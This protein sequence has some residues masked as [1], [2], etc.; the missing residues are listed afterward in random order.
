METLQEQHLQ[1]KFISLIE[2]YD[3]TVA[4]ELLMDLAIEIKDPQK[5]LERIAEL[6]D[7]LEIRYAQEEDLRKRI[8]TEVREYIETTRRKSEIV[9]SCGYTLFETRDLEELREELLNTENSSTD[10]PNN[11][12]YE[13]KKLGYFEEA[14]K[15][16]LLLEDP[17]DRSYQL[18]ELG[19]FKNSRIAALM[20]ADPDDRSYRL[21]LLG[22][23]K[24]SKIAALE[25]SDPIEKT[26]RLKQLGEIEEARKAA[27][28]IT[29]PGEKIKNLLEIG[30]I[31]SSILYINEIEETK[32]RRDYIKSIFKRFR[33]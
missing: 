8:Q 16:S 22:D 15:L 29:D 24:A 19:D 11:K 31:I 20:I 28:L 17:S 18:F 13:L 25:I 32:T 1:D 30:D 21:F 23:F 14:R 7:N 27:L 33:K 6:D 5:K 10:D 4:K 2:D 3:L 9:I 26:Y 12:I